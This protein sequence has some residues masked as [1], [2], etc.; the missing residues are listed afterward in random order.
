M[1]S[2]CVYDASLKALYPY[3]HIKSELW[4]FRLRDCYIHIGVGFEVAYLYVSGQVRRPEEWD[5][6]QYGSH[7]F[8]FIVRMYS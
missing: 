7:A 5:K 6:L 3:F 2:G 4:R 1:L 8:L